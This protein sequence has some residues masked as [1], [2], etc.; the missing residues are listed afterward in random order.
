MLLVSTS[1]GPGQ[2]NRSGKSYFSLEALIACKAKFQHCMT[3]DV[4]F[5][6]TPA[7]VG[8]KPAQCGRG[9]ELGVRTSGG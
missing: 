2:T 3:H 1:H 5:F 8:R 7:Q 4:L 9:D 6:G